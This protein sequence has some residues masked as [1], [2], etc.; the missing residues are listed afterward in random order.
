[1]RIKALLTSLL[2][3][4]TTIAGV[5]SA[6][7]RVRDH[8]YPA[9]VTYRPASYQGQVTV[10][11]TPSWMV[12]ANVNY[13]YQLAAN[14]T[15][16]PYAYGNDPYVEGISRNQWATISPCVELQGTGNVRVALANRSLRSLELQATQGQA[17]I[18]KI[19]VQYKDGS[20]AQFYLNRSLDSFH[21]PNLRLDLGAKGLSGVNAITVWGNGSTSFRVI[22]A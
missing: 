10:Q 20:H 1:M 11:T 5:A 3:A 13:G 12:N 7:P 17:Q 9:P 6:S 8:R 2:L 15:I 4:S 21:A 19:N 16:Q 14:G 18:T 22:A